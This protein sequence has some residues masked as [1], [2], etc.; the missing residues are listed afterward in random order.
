MGWRVS[1]D[2]L[3]VLFS[4]DIPALIRDRYGDAAAAFLARHGLGFGDIGC[5]VA[6]P[7]GA[8]VL[9]AMEDVYGLAPG[10]LR[11]AR[12]VLRRFGN[13][14]AATALFVLAEALAAGEKGR[15]LLSAL[16]PGFTAGF[17]LMGPSPGAAAR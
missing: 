15:L 2:G 17:L 16:G 14:S 12:A 10:G 6:H 1:G 13:M 11:H 8:K 5:F 3:G 4:R 9:S 7:G